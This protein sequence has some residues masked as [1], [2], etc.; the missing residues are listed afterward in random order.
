MSETWMRESRPPPIPLAVCKQFL[1]VCNRGVK[2]LIVHQYDNPQY[3]DALRYLAEDERVTNLGLCNFDTEHLEAVL[4]NDIQ[5]QSN[6]IQVRR[7]LIESRDI[8]YG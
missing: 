2:N 7:E 1:L 8:A 6:Q 4:S 5:I 3:L